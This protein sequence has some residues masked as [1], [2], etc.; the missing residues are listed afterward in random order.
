M[1]VDEQNIREMELP[2]TRPL[3]AVQPKFCELVAGMVPGEEIDLA[4]TV[5]PVAV[6]SCSPRPSW[7][8]QPET[9]KVRSFWMAAGLHHDVPFSIAV[10]TFRSCLR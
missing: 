6:V 1:S 8:S 3:A 2:R 7:P 9:A 10:N 5:K 4:P